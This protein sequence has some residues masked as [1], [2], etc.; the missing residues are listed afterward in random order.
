[1]PRATRPST[2][3]RVSSSRI[4]DT[5]GGRTRVK[6]RGLVPSANIKA[7]EAS[8]KCPARLAIHSSVTDKARREHIQL[9]LAATYLHLLHVRST[10]AATDRAGCEPVHIRTS[11]ATHDDFSGAN[12][13]RRDRQRLSRFSNK[14]RTTRQVAS[15]FMIAA[16]A[17]RTKSVAADGV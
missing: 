5:S 15:F 13:S 6:R 3:T 4:V 2:P 8:G 11:E 14:R 17:R 16:A 9:S 1:M 7:P 12:N 10:H